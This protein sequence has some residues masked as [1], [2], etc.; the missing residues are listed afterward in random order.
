MEI[1]GGFTT[2]GQHI[3]GLML[4]TVF[5]RLTGGYGR[6]QDARFSAWMNLCTSSIVAYPGLPTLDCTP[7]I[8]EHTHHFTG[9]IVDHLH[10]DILHEEQGYVRQNCS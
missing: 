8:A 2:Y 6:Y 10:E 7:A 9:S 4:D 5:P 1:N 3:G